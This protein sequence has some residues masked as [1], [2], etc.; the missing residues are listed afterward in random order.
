[1]A[2]VG[3]VLK[4]IVAPLFAGVTVNLL[5]QHVVAA[6]VAALLLLLCFYLADAVLKSR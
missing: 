6:I 4:Y 3:D 1:M 5:T 2:R